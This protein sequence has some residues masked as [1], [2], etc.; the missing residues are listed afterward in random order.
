MI[1]PYD[2]HLTLFDINPDAKISFVD[3]VIIIDDYYK[4]YED[5]YDLSQNMAV[6]RFKW[7]KG[8]S[9]NFVDYYDCR[10]IIHG[11]ASPMSCAKHFATFSLIKKYFGFD[12]ELQP[13]HFGYEFNYF[14]HIQ[15]IPPDNNIQFAPHKDPYT[16]A[17]IIYLD[18]VSSGGTIFYTNED[19]FDDYVF[20]EHIDLLVDVKNCSSRIVRAKPN[21]HIIFE[22]SSLHGG[23][24]EDHQKYIND[25]R[26]NQV[27]FYKAV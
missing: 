21:R 25:W 10:P 22:G 6:P 20:E 26:I 7:F 3:G 5:I 11:E 4:N 17:S 14:K 19:D 24:I 16:F 18:K 23:Y 13:L 1:I 27:L 8:E 2:H 15:N 12:G 9:R